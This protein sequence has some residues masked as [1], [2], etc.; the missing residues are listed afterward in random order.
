MV[1]PKEQ[2]QRV[3][4]DNTHEL[5]VWYKDYRAL[6]CTEHSY[7]V[8]NVSSYLR[9]YHYRSTKEKR[10][11]ADIF[12]DYNIRAPKD[13]LLPPPLGIPLLALGKP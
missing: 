13:I 1:R 11:V 2:G 12:T 8:Q 10:A 5:F 9:V 7:A 3:T 6:V 4:V